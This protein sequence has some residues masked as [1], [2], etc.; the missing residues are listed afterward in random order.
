MHTVLFEIRSLLLTRDQVLV[1]DNNFGGSFVQ[2]INR[3]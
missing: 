2:D 3:T 1:L